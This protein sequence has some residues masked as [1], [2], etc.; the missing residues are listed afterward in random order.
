MLNRTIRNLAITAITIV[1][2]TMLAVL[3]VTGASAATTYKFIVNSG[4]T[5]LDI[6]ANGLGEPVTISNSG[7]DDNWVLVNSQSWTNPSTE[8]V[9]VSELQHA[10][11]DNCINLSQ[12]AFEI[13]GCVAGDTDEL[14]WVELTGSTTDGNPNVWLINVAASDP[15][16][17]MFV[18]AKSL[19]NGATLVADPPGYGGL[20]A[21]NERCSSSC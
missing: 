17:Y 15:G 13:S 16:I 2:A 4:N 5:A 6:T 11:T 18:T 1:S 20:A 10:G 8:V 21:W 9:Q 3:S 7:T 19:T 12:G 14:F